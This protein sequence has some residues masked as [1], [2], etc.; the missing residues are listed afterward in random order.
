MFP[1]GSLRPVT[2]FRAG[3][4]IFPSAPLGCASSWSSSWLFTHR[5]MG[6]GIPCGV[7]LVLLRLSPC[8]PST[9]VIVRSQKGKGKTLIFSQQSSQLLR[10]LRI[11]AF[12]CVS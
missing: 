1:K 6:T 5:V 10:A 4:G 9:G 8:P 2:S 11:R 7:G 12:I 3:F